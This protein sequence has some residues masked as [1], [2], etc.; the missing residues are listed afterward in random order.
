MLN[1][2]PYMPPLGSG[3]RPTHRNHLVDISHLA[4]FHTTTIGTSVLHRDCRF[5]KVWALRYLFPFYYYSCAPRLLWELG[6]AGN[7]FTVDILAQLV[8]IPWMVEAWISW[9]RT[10][11]RPWGPKYLGRGVK[12]V[13]T[14]SSLLLG[15]AIYSYITPVEFQWKIMSFPGVDNPQNSTTS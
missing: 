4:K 3:V 11:L 12:T 9:V 7:F 13:K 6:S 15:R 8:G 1:N 5:E 2:C 14:S 10:Y